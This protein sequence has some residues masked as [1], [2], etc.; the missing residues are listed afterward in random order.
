VRLRILISLAA[1]TV[2][3]ALPA[4]AAAAPATVLNVRA[5]QTGNSAKERLATFYARMRA[6]PG[7]NRMWMR[8]TL[9]DRSSDGASFV[10]TP[11]LAKWRKSRP[12]VRTFG[13]RQTITGLQRG[14]SYAATVEYR[15]LDSRNHT[16]RSIRRTSADCHQDGDLPNLAVKSIKA[17]AGAA[18]GTELYLVDVTNRGAGKAEDVKLD[19]FV[20]G[21]AADAAEID[22]IKP[23]ET[24]TKKITGP[25]CSGR[26]RAIVDRTDA[27]SETTEDDNSLR[28]RCPAIRR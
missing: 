16:I 6:V 23:G 1:V 3:L 11:K 7:T 22:L 26:V 28:V 17:Q 9:I 24:V 8:F 5:C 15:W 19:L 13:Y 12:G 18:S 4:S 14:G 10:A 27:I 21:A 20:D 25:A 2:L